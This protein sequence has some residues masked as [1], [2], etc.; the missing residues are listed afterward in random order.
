MSSLNKYKN[1]DEITKKTSSSISN[2]S[3]LAD[4]KDNLVG[5]IK[6]ELAYKR[7]YM[8]IDKHKPVK[9]RSQSFRSLKDKN[10]NRSKTNLQIPLVFSFEKDLST[11]NSKEKGRHALN[12]LHSNTN[13]RKRS[14]SST[15]V[16]HEVIVNTR[17]SSNDAR[18]ANIKNVNPQITRKY[19]SPKKYDSQDLNDKENIKNSQNST[20][21]QIAEDKESARK[22]DNILNNRRI[23]DICD[24]KKY[25]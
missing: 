13:I 14:S 1:D 21:K 5:D 2:K 3:T 17:P 19:E 23:Y 11:T 10:E 9:A 7:K 20:N 16:K 4:I 18:N 24:I 8:S 6:A 12:E 15:A 25:D 22:R